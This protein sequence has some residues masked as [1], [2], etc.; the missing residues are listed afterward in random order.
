MAV[1]D[2]SAALV[3]NLLRLQVDRVCHFVPQARKDLHCF[4]VN[5]LVELVMHVLTLESPPKSP[6]FL[7]LFSGC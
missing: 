2:P 3:K 1:H 7:A 4:L 5:S 6:D